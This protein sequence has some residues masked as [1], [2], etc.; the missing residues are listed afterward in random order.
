[1]STYKAKIRI[2]GIIT[3]LAFVLTQCLFITGQAGPESISLCSD[4]DFGNQDIA[5]FPVKDDAVISG[6]KAIDLASL[7]FNGVGIMKGVAGGDIIFY[8]FNDKYLGGDREFAQL[9]V[10]V[11]GERI[12]NHFIPKR[13]LTSL[14]ETRPDFLDCSISSQNS[15]PEYSID[16]NKSIKASL[17]RKN[18]FVLRPPLSETTRIN[19]VSVLSGLTRNC[20][21]LTTLSFNNSDGRTIFL[22]PDKNKY[23]TSILGLSSLFSGTGGWAVNVMRQIWLM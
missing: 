2:I 19:P 21:N 5:V 20:D 1:M 15:G 4:C 12:R 23:S 7:A 18:P 10:S 3:L 8:L 9:P 13:C 17:S 16:S 14:E 6:P 22:P 11:F